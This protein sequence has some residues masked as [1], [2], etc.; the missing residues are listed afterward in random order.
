MGVVEV[1]VDRE[2][3]SLRIISV[4]QRLAQATRDM[5][6]WIHDALSDLRFRVLHPGTVRAGTTIHFDLKDRVKRKNEFQLSR[7]LL[8]ACEKHNGRLQ[9]LSATYSDTLSLEWSN[10]VMRIEV[11]GPPTRHFQQHGVPVD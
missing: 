4:G 9:H 2:K 7:T 10:V 1:S 5:M 6:Y 8:K 11:T 3:A